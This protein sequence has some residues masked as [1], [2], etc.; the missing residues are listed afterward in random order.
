MKISMAVN[1]HRHRESVGSLGSNAADLK[2]GD[3]DGMVRYD[4]MIVPSIFPADHTWL[5][6]NPIQ[7][8]LILISC[9]PGIIP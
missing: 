7:V 1:V 2:A 5:G 9:H 8:L 4:L 3:G 6:A